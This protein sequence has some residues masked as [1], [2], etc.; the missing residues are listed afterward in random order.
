MARRPLARPRGFRE[1]AHSYPAPTQRRPLDQQCRIRRLVILMKYDRAFP[2]FS[3]KAILTAVN[4]IKKERPDLWESW[5]KLEESSEEEFYRKTFAEIAALIRSL[6]MTK[7]LSER[8]VLMLKIRKVLRSELSLPIVETRFT[9]EQI[10]R[11]VDHIKKSRPDLWE[12]WKVY[13]KNGQTFQE[14]RGA[15]E[16]LLKEMKITTYSSQMTDL[17][18]AI[19]HVVLVDAGVWKPDEI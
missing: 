5:K 17:I 9:K 7:T 16:A 1:P 13:E 6:N 10:S 8:T 14:I 11:S 3:P 18:T 12:A 19:R 2:I 4:F 15:L